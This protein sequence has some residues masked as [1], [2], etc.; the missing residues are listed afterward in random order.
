MGDERNVDK[1]SSHLKEILTMHVDAPGTGVDK[2]VDKIDP[3]YG[4][5]VVGVEVFPKS[6]S[7]QIQYDVRISGTS[8]LSSEI[9]DPT[10]EQLTQGSLASALADRRGTDSDTVDLVVDTDGTGDGTALVRVAIRPFPAGGD[11]GQ[12]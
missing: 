1:D 5:Q 4:F 2:I 7:S 6:T 11:V 12:S 10:A 9:T 8:V 3:G